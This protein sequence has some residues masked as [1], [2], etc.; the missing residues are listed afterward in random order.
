[1]E[2]GSQNSITV[3]AVLDTVTAGTGGTI[4]YNGPCSP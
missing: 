2:I 1:V 4:T 3:Q